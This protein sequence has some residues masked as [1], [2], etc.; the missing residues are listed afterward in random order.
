MNEPSLA[1]G[2][3]YEAIMHANGDVYADWGMKEKLRVYTDDTV[4]PGK[5]DS[6]EK[7]YHGLPAKQS[8][9]KAYGFTAHRTNDDKE[10]AFAG[11]LMGSSLSE[12][13]KAMKK[14][15]IVGCGS[16]GCG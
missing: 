3:V 7:M 14:A 15:A 4:T 1:L 2:K 5:S 10:D 8:V 11:M 6:L 13:K 12:A 9:P 16:S